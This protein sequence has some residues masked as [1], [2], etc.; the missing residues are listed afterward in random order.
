MVA[1]ALGKRLETEME[2]EIKENL[3]D[4]SSVSVPPLYLPFLSLSEISI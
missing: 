4:Q 3:P 2:V 1:A